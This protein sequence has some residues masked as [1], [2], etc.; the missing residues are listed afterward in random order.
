[1]P[2][3]V[4]GFFPHV[5]LFLS[6]RCLH[7]NDYWLNSLR[8]HAPLRSISQNLIFETSASLS[9]TLHD[10]ERKKQQQNVRVYQATFRPEYQKVR[11]NLLFEYQGKDRLD[12]STVR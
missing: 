8:D 12:R 6:P 4:V 3:S 2:F 1:M 9:I 5:R 7:N 10:V 11:E